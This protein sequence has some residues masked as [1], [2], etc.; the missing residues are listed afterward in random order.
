MDRAE[1]LA[2]RAAIMEYAGKLPRAE[3][4]RRAAM[5]WSNLIERIGRA[6][7]AASRSRAAKT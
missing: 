3:S 4:E 1:Y 6:S 7:I 5:E 2:E